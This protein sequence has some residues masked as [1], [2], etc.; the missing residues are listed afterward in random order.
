MSEPNASIPSITHDTLLGGRVQLCQPEK[1]MRASIDA[2]FLGAAVP[3]KTGEHIFEAGIGSGA[4]SLAVLARVPGIQVSG[5]DIAPNALAL[6]AHNAGLNGWHDTLHL[7]EMD[8][9]RATTQK[10]GAAG[11]TLP[12]DH[13]LA[14][15]PFNHPGQGR[16]PA[17]KARQIALAMPPEALEKWVARLAGLVRGGGTVTFIHRADALAALLAKMDRQLGALIVLPLAPRAGAPAKRVLV[18]GTRGSRAPMQL[19]AP[20]VLHQ[21]KGDYTCQTQAVL[22]DCLPVDLDALARHI[23]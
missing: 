9:T 14:N 15:P 11:A 20:W 5:V 1:G 13:A 2:V 18:R 16:A 21:A 10:L 22:R 19:L 4:A 7:F 6:A 8:I 12:F 23:K 3:A 17:S